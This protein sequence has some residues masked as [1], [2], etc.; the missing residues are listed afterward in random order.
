[1]QTHFVCCLEFVQCKIAS[2][3]KHG[4]SPLE[5]QEDLSATVGLYLAGRWVCI[6]LLALPSSS[7][8]RSWLQLQLIAQTGSRQAQIYLDQIVSN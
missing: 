8:P 3:Y 1:M 4:P 7:L 2:S 5:V 6:P